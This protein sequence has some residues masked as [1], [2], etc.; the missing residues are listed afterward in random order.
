[1]SLPRIAPILFALAA[2]LGL[3]SCGGETSDLDAGATATSAVPQTSSPE[4]DP[5]AP[6]GSMEESSEQADKAAKSELRN[7]FT[8]AKVIATDHEGRFEK[9][10]AGTPIDAAALEHENSSEQYGPSGSASA[11]VV[12]VL[13]R[14]VSGRNSD[15]WLVT[16]S[17]A[18]RFF[19]I[20]GATDGTVTFG[21]ADS[22]ANAVAACGES[23][24]PDD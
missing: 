5:A 16:A 21:V 9:D 11:D 12:S 8:A 19:C 10:A 2:A 4:S 18:G 3:A 20:H 14:D 23:S 24:W 7:A 15:I 22:E 6:A 1:M 17:T 13:V